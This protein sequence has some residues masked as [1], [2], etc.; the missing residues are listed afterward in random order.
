[1]RARRRSPGGAPTAEVLASVGTDYGTALSE[2]FTAVSD[3]LKARLA[4]LDWPQIERSLGQWGYA[5]T[6][7]V[8]SPAEC[9]DLIALYG[10][11]GRFRSTVD[12]ARYRFGIGE[13]RYFAAPLP[14]LVEALRRH[15][16][17]PLAGIANRWEAALARTPAVHP[18]TLEGLLALCRRRGQTKPTPLLLRYETG[19]YNCLHQDI[20]GDVV[21]PLQITCFLSRRGVDYTGGDFL[22]VEQRPRAQSRGEAI[23]T[24]QGEIVIFTTRHRP[25]EGTRGVYRCAMRHGV[26]RVASG[27]RYTL[28][29]MLAG[30]DEPVARIVRRVVR[31]EGGIPLATVVGTPLKT[32]P[33]WAALANGAAGHAHDFDDTNFALLGHP[34]VPLL[35][36]ALA[37]A[38]AEM[39]SGRALVLGYVVGFEVDVTLGRALNPDHYTR[40][41]H[42]TSSIG[43]LGCAAAA[44]RIMGLDLV[45]TRNALAIA[46][47]HA[48][49]LKENFGSMTKPYHAGHAARNGLLAAQLAR[50]GLTASETAPPSRS[51]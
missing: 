37:A 11:A 49:G 34:S 45:Q 17:P 14:P 7:A 48:S 41:W 51:A 33:G 2:D 9:A 4:R 38:E 50:E 36:T 8:L 12:M 27:S 46:A 39:G 47:S 15:A 25:V 24:E 29:V 19:G 3:D 42:A 6:P 5:K 44:A 20:Y 1:M 31:A 22:L 35:S 26:S 43:T 21:F 18:P 32:A 13:Y 23:A 28:G 10:D 40:G 16:Y 30:A